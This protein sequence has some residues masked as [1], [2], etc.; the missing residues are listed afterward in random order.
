MTKINSIIQTFEFADD[1]AFVISCLPSLKYESTMLVIAFSGVLT[2]IAQAMGL[3]LITV[4]AFAI[5]CVV[6]LIIGVYASVV[7]GKERLQSTK[8]SR[9]TVKLAAIMIV[10]FVLNT[11]QEQF[12]ESNNIASVFF[13]WFYLFVFA[14]F[15]TEYLISIIENIGKIYGKSTNSLVKAIKSKQKILFENHEENIKNSDDTNSS[16]DTN[17]L[18]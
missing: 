8:A 15:A 11:F 14:W 4:I 13:E 17:I 12:K 1:K 5:M 6:E 18:S 3:E 10:L 9:F 7:V 16:N 2:T